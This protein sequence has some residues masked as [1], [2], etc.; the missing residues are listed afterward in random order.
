MSSQF[1]AKA[2]LGICLSL[3]MQAFEQNAAEAAGQNVSEMKF[4]AF[5]GMPTCSNGAVVSGDPA[6]GPSIVLAKMK[7]GCVFPSHWHTASEHLMLVSG[8][9]H[10]EMKDAA[11]KTL[12]AGGFAV[13]PAHHVHSA[14][15]AKACLLYV[16]SDAA[17]DMHYVDDQGK[18]ISPDEALKKVRETAAPAPK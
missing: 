16:Y 11:A 7:P 9:L 1:F 18:E 8:T 12:G 13:M 14:H 17:F 5:P 3:S 6:K 2:L 4:A 15:C 10:L